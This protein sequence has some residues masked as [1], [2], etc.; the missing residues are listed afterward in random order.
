MNLSELLKKGLV[1][2]VEPD[3]TRAKELLSVA[4]RNI[5]AAVDNLK[6]ENFDWAF[7]ISYNS[8]LSAGRALMAYKGY[9]PSSDSHHFAVVQFCASSFPAESSGLVSTFN[10]YRV[11]R[12]DIVY[13]ETESVGRTEAENAIGNAKDFL[14]KI[15]AKMG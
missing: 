1:R 9:A 4:E 8:M 14:E 6:T 12:H 7:A 2:K 15:K 13:G 11:R 10:R 5:K 3:K